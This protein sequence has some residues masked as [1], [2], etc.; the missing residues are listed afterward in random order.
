MYT[1]ECFE[2]DVNSPTTI[3]F[4]LSQYAQNIGDYYDIN[5][6]GDY[7]DYQGVQRTVDGIIH[8]KRDQ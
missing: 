7:Y 5:F 8:V 3:V 2:I 6:S 4:N 1:Y